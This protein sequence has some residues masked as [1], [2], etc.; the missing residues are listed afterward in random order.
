MMQINTSSNQSNQAFSSD[1]EKQQYSEMITDYV[2]NQQVQKDI[3]NMVHAKTRR[4]KV[5]MDSLRQFNPRLAS[6]VTKHPIEAI[7]MFED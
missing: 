4:F 6:F 2:N 5:N 7:A 3:R 1:V